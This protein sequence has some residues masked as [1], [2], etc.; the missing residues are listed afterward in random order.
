MG[1]E[2]VG[3]CLLSWERGRLILKSVSR[4]VIDIVV[5]S[6]PFYL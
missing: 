2:S 6:L 5:A 3:F 4:V 1:G